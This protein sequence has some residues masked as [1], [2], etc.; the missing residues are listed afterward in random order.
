[1]KNLILLLTLLIIQTNFLLAQA[2]KFGKV[3]KEE[4]SAAS[5]AIE[6]D[7][8]AAII[9]Q[10]GQHYMEY[11]KSE[12]QFVLI[13]EVY[14]KIKIY[15]ASDDS[16]ANVEVSLYNDNRSK[17]KI[18]S[19]KA[20]TYNLESN[21]IKESKL[22]KKNIFEEK[23]S[24]NRMSKKF[25]LPNVKDGSIIEY[26]YKISSPFV[27]QIDRWYFQYDI[28]C[29]ETM[30]RFEH[31]EYYTYRPNSTGW[32]PLNIETAQKARVV[33]FS[34]TRDVSDNPN[35]VQKKFFNEKVDY[36]GIVT[37]ITQSNT[38]SI[39]AEK[40]I[41]SLNSLRSSIAYEL[42]STSWP[43]QSYKLYTQ[44]WD[45][46]AKMLHDDGDFG[47]QLNKKY[48][49]LG[50]IIDQ[51]KNQ[52]PSQAVASIY[53]YFQSNY[54]FNG[55]IGLNL[56]N[57]IKSLIKTG[58]GSASEINLL[59]INTLRKAGV[60]VY[61]VVTKTRNSGVLNTTYPT[62]S[63][64]N[65]VFAAA[66]IDGKTVY[67]DATDN[68]ILPGQLPLRAI[69]MQ[70]VLLN[71]DSGTAINIANPNSSIKSK[72]M[73][74]SLDDDYNLT[75]AVKQKYKGI[76]ANYYRTNYAKAKN[77]DAWMDELE[78]SNE[79]LDY[80]AITVENGK[81]GAVGIDESYT[82]EGCS[83]MIGD[84]IYIDALLG[85]GISE[86]PFVAEKRE[87]PIF[88]NNKT[89]ENIII[90]IDI[91]EGYQLEKIPEKAI[92]SLPEKMGLFSYT[93]TPL[94]GKLQLHYNFR[95]NDPIISPMYYEA[96]K[97]F[98]DLAVEKSKEKIVLSKKV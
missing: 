56:D 29:N 37:T 35:V 6:P 71:N 4:I 49:E 34:F 36:Q 57:G 52:E 23:V 91:P 17:E 2:S 98:Y 51:S 82:I 81:A 45:Q 94:D 16:Y 66:V 84:K 21:K 85:N 96:V 47:K 78:S 20:V 13:T 73:D 24:K 11:N 31:P 22:D 42:V 54:S 80:E 68:N 55:H 62:L 59:L 27:F 74:V 63:D 43:G 58:E 89:N 44:T 9:Y 75:C 70:G 69:N 38:P 18:N 12:K 26:K 14:R 3:N 86:N 87:Y 19:I 1:M 88:Y 41:T 61:P 79:N 10:E 30:Y 48:N 92:V 64:L 72:K 8:K 28:P 67:L 39:K 83:E 15:D 50:P 7:A 32:L 46:I 53:G 76:S 97:K 60:E 77:N 90:V 40:Y 93:P 95:I 65:Y 25:A 5:H 33:N